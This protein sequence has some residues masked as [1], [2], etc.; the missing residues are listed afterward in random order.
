[1]ISSNLSSIEH[2]AAEL[3]RDH[4]QSIYFRTDRMFI[5]LMSAQWIVAIA[6]ALWISPQA[7]AG[8]V[9]TTHPHVWAAILLGGVNTVPPVG[10]ALWRPGEAITRYAIA[11]GQMLMSG[12]LIH[13]MGGRLE[14]HFHVFGSLAFLAFYR[15]WTVFIPA[16]VVVAVDHMW[17]GLFWPESVFG[18]SSVSSW[19][20]M[21]HAGWVLFEDAFLIA[22]CRWSTREMAEIATSRARLERTHELVEAEVAQRTAELRALEKQHVESARRA[23]MAD[24]ATSVL[25]NVGN[26]LNS[27]NVSASLIGDRLKQ[28][29][30][31]DFKRAAD[32]I[33]E[34]LDDTAAY[35]ERDPRG[36]HLPRFL[37]ELS[38]KMTDDEQV[39]LDEVQNLSKGIEHIKEV[40]SRQQSYAGKSEF[41]EEVSIESLL[42]DAIR[43]NSSSSSRCSIEFIRE[44]SKLP[45]AKIDQHKLLQ[46][47]INLLSNARNAVIESAHSAPQIT[48]RAR[49]SETGQLSVEVSDNGIGIA[50]ENLTRIFSHGFTTRKTG[51]G[52]GL[53]SA[54]NLARE[55]GG[56][57]TATSEGLG[58]GATFVLNL[59]LWKVE[60]TSCLPS[61]Q[62]T[63]G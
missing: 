7:W 37:I 23:G 25:H 43:I 53:H 2:R 1:L 27:V 9:H 3:L 59:P 29:G 55:M 45:V 42:E 49:C 34:H 6:V 60:G 17:R 14:T 54:A 28:S 57:L 13:L 20:W 22:S 12:L 61:R 35:I 50:P 63:T 11:L 39:I 19:R 36:R 8:T 41:V 58:C 24:I 52:F 62:V 51:H 48:I 44:Y 47:L 4:Q 15:D 30:T 56:R 33:R 16:T 26:V 10:L 5:W 32:L 18:I 40:V 21:E 38:G 31:P 46:I